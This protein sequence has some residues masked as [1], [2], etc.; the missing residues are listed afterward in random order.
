MQD[1]YYERKISILDWGIIISALLLLLVV[2]IPQSIWQEEEKFKKEGRKRMS[3]IVNAEDFYFEMTGKYTLDG[4]HLFELVEAAMDSLIA[5]SLFTGEK[6]I[7]IGENTYPVTLERGFEIRVDTTFSDPT[8]IYFSYDDTVYSIELHNLE[9]GGTD[10]LF[11]NVRDLPNFQA[12]N[13]FK[14]ILSKE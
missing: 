12:D 14:K 10:T 8:E 9:L 5:D 13:N 3:D 1:Q 2:Y 11:V 7:R 4:E 6:I